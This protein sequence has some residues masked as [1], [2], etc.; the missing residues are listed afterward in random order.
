MCAMAIGWTWVAGVETII[1]PLRAG[2]T[3]LVI[4]D[5][6]EAR[7]LMAAA[8]DGEGFAVLEASTAAQAIDLLD[9]GRVPALVITDVLLPHTSVWD[10]LTTSVQTRTCDAPCPR[11]HGDRSRAG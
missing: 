11:D 1:S 5:N 3:V 8:L 7:E 10:L 2:P 9:R 6:D 4:E